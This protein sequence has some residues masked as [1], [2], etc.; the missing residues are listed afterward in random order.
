MT[1]K[2]YLS[3]KPCKNGCF[4]TNRYFSTNKC[5]S[6]RK[7]TSKK[8]KYKNREILKLS[9][10]EYEEKNREK[11]NQRQKIYRENNKDKHSEY[12]KN[13]YE[14]NQE[15]KTQYAKRKREENP[16]KSRDATRRWT[17]NNKEKIKSYIFKNKEKRSTI[18]RNRRARK[19]N[20]FDKHNEKDVLNI[21]TLQRNKC[22]N[23]FCVLEKYHVDHIVPLSKNGSNGKKNIQILCPPCNLS[24]H[25]KDPIKWANENGRLL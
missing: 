3:E 12:C 15:Y 14:K 20:S 4:P 6:C 18:E 24:K 5:V 19:N 8:Y 7:K 13:W 1:D 17:S 23:C 21:K 2:F 9:R 25:A 10:K 16:Q 11:I 22:A